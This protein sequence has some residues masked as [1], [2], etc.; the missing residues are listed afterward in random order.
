MRQNTKGK[1]GK[2]RAS[3]LSDDNSE[4]ATYDRA[5][6]VSDG[7]PKRKDTVPMLE[8][9]ICT[10]NIGT[11]TGRSAELSSILE[12]R[13]I[14]IC[15]VQETKWKGAKSR[16]IGKGYKLLYN[17]RENTK[18]GIGIILDQ[19][20]SNNVVGIN[21]ISDRIM[22]VKLA[23][24]KQPCLNVIS[25]YA[26]QVNCQD[27]EKQEFWEELQSLVTTIPPGEQKLICGDLNGH[28]GMDGGGY[29]GNH[30]GFGFGEQNREGETILDFASCHDLAVVNTFFQKKDEHLIT[31]KSGN[32]KTQIDYILIDKKD[33]KQIKDCKVIPGEPLTSQH[34]LLL[35][36]LK[37]KTPIKT[38]IP[39]VEKIKWHALNGDKGKA[40]RDQIIEYLGNT[41]PENYSSTSKLW[42]NFESFCVATVKRELG[43]SK[44]A[45]HSAKDAKWWNNRAKDSVAE[46]KR[47]FK[48]WQNTRSEEDREIYIQA[49]KAARKTVAV[50]RERKPSQSFISDWN[51]R[52][53]LTYIK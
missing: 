44:G 10:W 5:F 19:Y 36:A 52:L 51:H 15:C 23:L 45:L 18:N 39:R 50:E 1:S 25:V 3:P 32:S 26:P 20:L 31:Y 34:R 29:T 24:N 46:K 27:A 49:K 43:V 7:I 40:V 38:K 42:E 21:R 6:P 48:I 35:T 12:R 41:S 4:Y 33:L 47:L 16:Q 11:M 28:V 37:L 8:L 53:T 14:N 9:R 30:G 2:A 22:S 13:R 17:G